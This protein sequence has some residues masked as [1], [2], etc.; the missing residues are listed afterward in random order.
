MRQCPEVIWILGRETMFQDNV[1]TFNIAEI[2]E[3]FH[4]NAQI[5]LFFFGTARVPKDT[6]DGNFVR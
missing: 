2:V 1:F 3:R 5:N 6:N 4:D